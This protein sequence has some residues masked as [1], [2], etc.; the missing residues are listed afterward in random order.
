MS[1]PNWFPIQWLKS[2]APV[3][4]EPGKV[5]P[6]DNRGTVFYIEYQNVTF[7]VTAKHVL[8]ACKN[9]MLC[10]YDSNRHIQRMSSSIISKTVNLKWINHPDNSVDISAIPFIVYDD[11]DINVI[12]ETHWN[13]SCSLDP[14]DEIMHI[15]YPELYGASYADGTLAYFPVGLIGTVKF[16]DNVK[17]VTNTN[18]QG[19]A[20]GGPLFVNN[21]S[22]MPQLIGIVYRSIPASDPKQN[23]TSSLPISLLNDLLESEQMKKQFSSYRKFLPNKK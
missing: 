14:S 21:G 5:V 2:A 10:Y 18:G 7:A 4:T 6:D 20:S 9:P 13:L 22:D 23:K 15:G 16:Y 17:I 12:P 19:G 1:L 3:L 11:M 8:D